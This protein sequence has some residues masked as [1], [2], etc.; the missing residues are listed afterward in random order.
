MDFSLSAILKSSGKDFSLHLFH[1]LAAMH[2]DGGFTGT[3]F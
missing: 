3:E 2:F 1:H